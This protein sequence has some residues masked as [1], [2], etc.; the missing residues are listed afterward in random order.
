MSSDL[1]A[2]AEDLSLAEQRVWESEARLRRLHDP[3]PLPVSWRSGDPD[4]FEE[5][6]LLCSL[7]RAGPCG[8]PVD[9]ALWPADSE[10]LAG[11]GPDIVEVFS[12]RLP[13]R[14]LVV[15][16]EPGAGKTVLLIR[17]LLGLLHQRPAHGPVP[18]LLSLASWDPS[19]KPLFSWMAQ[20]LRRAHPALTAP[21]TNP[22]T[23]K[24]SDLAHALL[25]SGR[26]LPFLDGFDELPVGLRAL[27][28]DAI[29][30]A[31]PPGHPAV[32][33]SR[34]AE[35]RAAYLRLG[36]VAR[37]NG[38]AGI[39]LLP[40]TPEQA[41][42]YLRRDA[43]GPHSPAAHRWHTVTRLLGTGTPVGQAL[44]TPFGLFL[45]RTIY[46]PRPGAEPAHASHPDDLCDSRRFP[47]RARVEAHLL[48]AFVPSA[49]ATHAHCSPEKARRT[50]AFLARHLE[51]NHRG[52]P[53]FFWWDLPY[54]L[55]PCARRLLLG[56]GTCCAFGL[57]F[58]LIAG[59]GRSWLRCGGSP[60]VSS[61]AHPRSVP[62]G[63]DEDGG[64][65]P[66]ARSGSSNIPHPPAAGRRRRRAG[67]R[68]HRWGGGP[69]QRR[70]RD[71]SG[72]RR[73]GGVRSWVLCS[74][75]GTNELAHRG[76]PGIRAPFRDRNR[77]RL[78]HRT[79]NQR[80]SRS[81]FGGLER[82]HQRTRPQPRPHG[83]GILRACPVLPGSVTPSPM[84][85]DDVPHGRSPEGRSST[86]RS[87]VPVSPHRTPAP[88]GPPIPA[89][90]LTERSHPAQR[91]STPR[92]RRPFALCRPL[93]L[94]DS[95]P[96]C[97][98][99][100]QHQKGW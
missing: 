59:L 20:R 24:T 93:P 95:G 82:P 68:D 65:G 2:V 48:N 61:S 40:L 33:A 13:T 64:S 96:R 25:D 35:Y 70:H 11:S 39:R 55:S 21:V 81:R 98:A 42:T 38:A 15:L 32:L 86:G 62:P 94:R 45:A 41:A 78:Q 8:L 75:R 99:A 37:F 22:R 58:A 5:W 31:L 72:V 23:G 12:R 92:I 49:Y 28:L 90:R 52:S 19:R 84:A 91:T 87:H 97:G 51:D 18:V 10:G 53:D 4:L 74:H 6:S 14:R 9:S 44:S 79:G 16:G 54:A 66:A 57:P 83:L 77:D 50:F 36:T 63:L 46:N 80:R 85:P 71:R 67:R 73:A 27:A 76:R 29:N 7:A 34:T 88:P 69:H 56:S 89:R 43:G 26:I 3:Y 47:T 100:P 17:L 30:Q 60:C 1:D